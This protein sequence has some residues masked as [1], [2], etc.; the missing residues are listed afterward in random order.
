LRSVEFKPDYNIRPGMF[1]GD[2]AF[3]LD[4][5][6]LLAC[7]YASRGFAWLRDSD[8]REIVSAGDLGGAF[9]EPE[10]TRLLVSIAAHVRVIQDRE[11]EFFNQVRKTNCGRLVRD[12][13][14]PR[15]SEP[16]SWREAC[17]K[18]IH[19]KHFHVDL[20]RRPRNPNDYPPLR[21]MIY[22]YWTQDRM[23][24][25]ATLNI[26]AFVSINAVLITGWT[27]IQSHRRMSASDRMQTLTNFDLTV[28]VESRPGV[29]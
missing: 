2:A 16:L 15:K 17:N 24:W 20:Q 25:K 29:A 26:D 1:F 11:R 5:Y 13:K 10:I 28:P 22:L 4:L 7:F 8:H 27:A 3:K 18:I 21:A 9:E 14:H 19:S 12:L 6:R 23:E